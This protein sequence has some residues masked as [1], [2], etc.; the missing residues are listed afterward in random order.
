MR[1][2]RSTGSSFATWAVPAALAAGCALWSGSAHAQS[3]YIDENTSYTN[4]PPCVNNPDLNTV[5]A[6][7]QTTMVNSGWVGSRFTDQNSWPQDFT[8]A[9]SSTSYGPFGDDGA[10]AD[11]HVLAVFAGH[12]LPGLVAWGYPHDNV[13]TRD[14]KANIRLGQMS[15][16]QAAAAMWLG[17]E[18]LSP[19]SLP[20]EGNYE[21]LRQQ[22]GWVNSI[23][24]DDDEPSEFFNDTAGSTNRDAWLNDMSGSGREPIV[25]T[26]DNYSENNCWIIHYAASLGDQQYTNPRGAGPSCGEGLI[27]YWY[28]YEYE[29]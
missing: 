26:Y 18:V 23:G 7:L 20:T 21:W 24:I 5:T 17:C 10:F 13:C 28:C 16:A 4:H 11:E 9:C 14:F 22:F 19:T 8:E 2:L 15:G 3:F 1:N 25:V 6:S 12:A 27:S 29:T